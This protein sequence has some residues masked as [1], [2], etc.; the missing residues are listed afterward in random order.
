M[1]AKHIW[2]GTHSSQFYILWDRYVTDNT[3][4]PTLTSDWWGRPEGCPR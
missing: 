1:T 3:L 4:Y 2:I